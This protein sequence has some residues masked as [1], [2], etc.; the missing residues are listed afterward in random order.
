[1]YLQKYLHIVIFIVPNV[2]NAFLFRVGVVRTNSSTSRGDVQ[3]KLLDL[4]FKF[5]I[6]FRLVCS[7]DF[8]N[9]QKIEI[10]QED[11]S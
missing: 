9:S 7:D 6:F 11:L 10:L 3:T 4:D 1:M 2:L 8:Y 5:G